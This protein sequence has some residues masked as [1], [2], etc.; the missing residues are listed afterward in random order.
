MTSARLFI[1][2]GVAAA[3]AGTGLWQWA[4]QT[5]PAAAPALAAPAIAP[6][7]IYAMTFTDE[8]GAIRALGQFQG[9]LLVLNFWATWC[10]PCRAE[11]PAFERLHRAWSGQG[12]RFV[13]LSAEPADLAARFG[14]ELGV[15]YPL[16][17][18]GDA[19]QELSRRLGNRGSVLPH[20]V[21]LGPSG[22]VLEQR[23]GPYTEAELSALLGRLADK[24]SQRRLSSLK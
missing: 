18:G 19:V 21:V 22:V 9:R 14:R 12:V 11:M 2:I 17:T 13:G 5:P 4:R 8:S 20:T 6:A 16:W 3:A 15:S 24:S 1:A 10:A 23:V 7:A